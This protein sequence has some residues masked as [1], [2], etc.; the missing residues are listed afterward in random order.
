M[1]RYDITFTNSTGA[2]IYVAYMRLDYGCQTECG[3]PWDV[4]GWINRD[5]GERQTRANP[6]EN[7]WFYY[8]AESANGAVGPALRCRSDA[9]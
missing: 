9:G 8:Y 3:D 1:G 7:K 5:T 6:T 2:K 4:L